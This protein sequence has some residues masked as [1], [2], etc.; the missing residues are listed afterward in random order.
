MESL[1]EWKHAWKLSWR[2]ALIL[3]GMWLVL[4]IFFK[5]LGI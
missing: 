4:G 2:I 5:L 1:M 3:F